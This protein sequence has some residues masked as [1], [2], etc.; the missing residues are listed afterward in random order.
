MAGVAGVGSLG[1]AEEAGEDA[2]EEQAKGGHADA[3]E[4][5]VDLDGGPDADFV[6]V[7]GWVEGVG[8]EADEGLETKNA[9]DSDT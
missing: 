9:D 7:P 3:D 6:E 2:D 1:C 8:A 4:A 5:D